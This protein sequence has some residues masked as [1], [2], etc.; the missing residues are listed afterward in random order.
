MPI[1]ATMVGNGNVIWERF[2]EQTKLD[3]V[4]DPLN[5]RFFLKTRA[6]AKKDVKVVARVSRVSHH[7]AN[8][9]PRSVAGRV[10]VVKYTTTDT[11][12]LFRLTRLLRF[13]L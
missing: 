12:N 10:G 2:E 8:A 4:G 11:T 3:F 9:S 7:V 1:Q 5:S 13:V 6:T